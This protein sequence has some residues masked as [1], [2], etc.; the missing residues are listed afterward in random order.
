MNLST[1]QKQT[2]GHGEQTLVAKGEVGGS[3]MDSEFWVS[4]Y[5]LLHLGRIGNELLLYSIGNYIQS[6]VIEMKEYGKENIYIYTYTYVCITGS[7]CC[8]VEIDR[9]L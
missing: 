8:T 5:K 7:L 6:L 9:T 1:E 3:G 2:L 4:G